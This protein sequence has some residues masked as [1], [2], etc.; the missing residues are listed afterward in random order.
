MLFAGKPEAERECL[1]SMLPILDELLPALRFVADLEAV[2]N[3]LP[4]D[5][6][7]A[8]EE[9]LV[10]RDKDHQKLIDAG[11]RTLRDKAGTL[12]SSKHKKVALEIHEFLDNWRDH[13]PDRLKVIQANIRTVLET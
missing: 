7:K 3:D 4:A 1:E 12:K 2:W 13:E 9:S 11:I 5:E 6:Q 8:I 10:Y